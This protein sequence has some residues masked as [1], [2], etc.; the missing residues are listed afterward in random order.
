MDGGIF[1]EDIMI[2]DDECGGFA[3]VFQVL[4]FGADGG[5]GKELII[6][7]DFGVAVDDDVGVEFTAVPKGDVRF[8]DTV[9]PD[10][11]VGSD[12]GVGG[13]DCGGMNHVVD[14]RSV[15]ESSEKSERPS[16]LA[17]MSFHCGFGDEF[18]HGFGLRW[19]RI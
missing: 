2:S 15:A 8:D 5:E 7:T 11:D 18:V 3:L 1:T 13:D 4:R 19:Q 10:L 17:S 6:F 9:G 14:S 16:T 12:L